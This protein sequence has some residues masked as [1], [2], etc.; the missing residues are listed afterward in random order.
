MT[1][2]G[3]INIAT[4]RK[5]LV[6]IAKVEHPPVDYELFVDFR[7]TQCDLSISDVYQLA[8]ELFQYGDTFRRKVAL[9]VLPG[10]DFDR[11]HF[12]ETCSQNRGFFLVN[13]FTDY[14]KAMHWILS[15]ED[16]P[17]NKADA[18]NGK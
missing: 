6:D 9:L 12:F 1:P 7:D 4:S 10:I 14:E 11:A 8:T 17:D 3:M 5:L 2:D 18:N 16:L 15:D 13:A